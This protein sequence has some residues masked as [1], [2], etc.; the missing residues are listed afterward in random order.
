M[1]AQINKALQRTSIILIK[2]YQW[3]LRPWLGMHC[4]FHPSCSDY[5]LEAIQ[6]FGWLKGWGLAG[7]RLCRCHPWHSGGV[8]PVPSSKEK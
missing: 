3:C 8:D 1:L 2:A 4:R 6:R 5:A 7:K